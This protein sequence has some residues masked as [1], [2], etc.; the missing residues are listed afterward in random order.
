MVTGNQ[1]ATYDAWQ[2]KVRKFGIGDTL[3]I[4]FPGEKAYKLVSERA[5]YNRIYGK[6]WGNTRL[7]FLLVLGKAKLPQHLCKWLI[8]WQL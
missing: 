3:G 6:Y 2:Q 7:F 4:D 8:S 5:D 1:R